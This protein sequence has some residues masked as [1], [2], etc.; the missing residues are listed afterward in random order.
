MVLGLLLFKGLRYWWEQA[1]DSALAPGHKLHLPDLP[2]RPLRFVWGVRGVTLLVFAP[3][4]CDVGWY[5]SHR[6]ALLAA[7][8]G[9]PPGQGWDTVA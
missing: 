2:Q 6:K 7:S 9:P 5:R 4:L 8:T 1:L 3:V